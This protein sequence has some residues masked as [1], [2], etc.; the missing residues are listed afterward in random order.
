MIRDDGIGIDPQQPR[1]AEGP[2][3]LRVWGATDEQLG[4]GLSAARKVLADKGVTPGRSVVCHSAVAAHKLDPSLPEPDADVRA[5]AAACREAYVAAILAAG[6]VLDRDDALAFEQG[7]DD[8][9]LWDTLP[10]LRAWRLKNGVEA[11]QRRPG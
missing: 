8:R 1:R 9:P 2:L 5:G 11:D 3:E 6:G 4:A 7:D 10:T